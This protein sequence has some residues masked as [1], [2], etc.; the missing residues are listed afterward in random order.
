MTAPSDPVEAKAKKVLDRAA[1]RLLDEQLA[2]EA[3]SP[4]TPPKEQA[5]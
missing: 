1:R 2:R 3:E 5:A 4:V